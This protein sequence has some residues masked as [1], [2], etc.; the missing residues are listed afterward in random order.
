MKTYSDK[1]LYE[2]GYT[3]NALGVVTQFMYWKELVES[4]GVDGLKY[5]LPFTFFLGGGV[6]DLLKRDILARN[7]EVAT[8]CRELLA[9]E[10][11]W[12][13]ASSPLEAVEPSF[14]HGAPLSVERLTGLALELATRF[15]GKGMRFAL[16]HYLAPSLL[17]PE[18]SRDARHFMADFTR[19]VMSWGNVHSAEFTR[20]LTTE[21]AAYSAGVVD[22]AS[23]YGGAAAAVGGASVTPPITGPS[24]PTI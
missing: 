6:Y 14:A 9:G 12:G 3:P 2:L 15:E 17:S 7:D 4:Y 10:Y 13:Q 23:G 22:T 24:G 8:R 20:L 11:S 1:L 5:A 19:I 18:L 16:A 21:F